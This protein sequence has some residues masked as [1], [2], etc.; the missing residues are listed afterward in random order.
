MTDLTDITLVMV[1]LTFVRVCRYFTVEKD[2]SLSRIRESSVTSEWL[3]LAKS[4][5]ILILLY[6]FL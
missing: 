1:T 2:V 3:E 4:Y 6:Y 5:N